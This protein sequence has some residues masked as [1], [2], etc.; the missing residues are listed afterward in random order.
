[1]TDGEAIVIVVYRAARAYLSQ[2]DL[3]AGSRE[4]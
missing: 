4:V 1:M 3:E 2:H